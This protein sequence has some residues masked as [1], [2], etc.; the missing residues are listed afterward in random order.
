M[1]KITV[2]SMLIL[3]IMTTACEKKPA[4]QKYSECT[5]QKKA[6]YIDKGANVFDG[7]SRA[8]AFCEVKFP[9]LPPYY[10]TASAPETQ[11]GELDFCTGECPRYRLSLSKSREYVT[12]DVTL[13]NGKKERY[14]K[15]ESTSDGI[16]FSPGGTVKKIDIIETW[17]D[18]H[19]G[20]HRGDLITPQIE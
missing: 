3:G 15:V 16:V 4:Y 14:Q 20:K 12:F 5:D 11:I 6:E 13:D 7:T 1:K 2:I 9:K 8:E 19:K 10:V 17:I 18:I